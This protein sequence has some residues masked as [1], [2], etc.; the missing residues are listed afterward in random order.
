MK[1]LFRAIMFGLV[2]A[3]TVAIDYWWESAPK[4][5]DEFDA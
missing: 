4:D 2:A 1:R 5:T 3:F